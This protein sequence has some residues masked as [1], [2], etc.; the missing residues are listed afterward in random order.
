MAVV[1]AW[2]TSGNSRA[3]ESTTRGWQGEKR[4]VDK[5]AIRSGRAV[6]SGALAA[7]LGNA[8]RS[9]VRR[10]RSRGQCRRRIHSCQLSRGRQRQECRRRQ[11]ACPCRRPGGGAALASETPGAGDGLQA[12]HPHR[13][14]QGGEPHLWRCRAQRAEF[15]DPVPRQPRLLV[16]SQRRALGAAIARHSLR[17]RTGGPHRFDPGDI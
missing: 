12:A 13:G 17:R 14:R 5:R 11:G 4:S 16:P 6:A 7:G 2:G 10:T 9:A 3:A 15:L 1:A 8:C